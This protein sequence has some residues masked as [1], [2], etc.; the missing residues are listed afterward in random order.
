MLLLRLANFIPGHASNVFFPVHIEL[1][2][3][4]KPPFPFGSAKVQSKDASLIDR[5]N[6]AASLSQ[7]WRTRTVKARGIS[8]Q[9]ERQIGRDTRPLERLARPRT[10]RHPDITIGLHGKKEQTS[11]EGMHTAY[12]DHHWLQSWLQICHIM[13]KRP[14]QTTC[15]SC[16]RPD[17]NIVSIYTV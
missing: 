17:F 12:V 8:Q 2:F 5:E 15:R 16:D 4:L 7:H 13:D 11:N 14:N 3:E 10:A 9:G 1:R 6:L